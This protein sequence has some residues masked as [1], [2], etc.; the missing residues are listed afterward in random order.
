MTDA[1]TRIRSILGQLQDALTANDLD[2]LS[3]LMDDDIVLFGTAAANMDR[4][5]TIAYITEVI[6]QEGT[7]RWGWDSVVPLVDEPGLLV[8]AGVG[9]VGF[10][11]SQGRPDG[12]RDQFRLTVV[13]VEREAGWRLSHFHASV[14]QED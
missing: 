13:A 9:T 5:E 10:E 3:A 12:P 1:E 6:A 4:R 7:V 14:P 2:A 8:F 11:D